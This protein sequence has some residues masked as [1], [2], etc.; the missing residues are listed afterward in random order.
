MYGGSKQKESA[1]SF[2]DTHERGCSLPGRPCVRCQL[3]SYLINTYGYEVREIVEGFLNGVG[4]RAE[5]AALGE[6]V[7]ALGLSKRVLALLN[8]HRIR[9]VRELVTMSEWELL[10]FPYLGRKSFYEIKEAL[11]ERGLYVGMDVGALPP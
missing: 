10:N 5:V 6:H 9:T 4:K 1:M 8:R 2:F 7:G 3:S 11:A